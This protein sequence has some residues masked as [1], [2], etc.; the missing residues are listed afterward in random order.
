MLGEKFGRGV[1]PLE[2]GY[3]VEI[4]IVQRRR[5]GLERVMRATDVDDDTI[6]IERLGDE[7]R[8]DDEGCAVQRLR[9]P[10][11]GAAERMGD[12]DVIANFNGEQGTSSGIS[13][14]L[15]KYA[16]PGVKNLG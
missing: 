3:L 11:H 12:H 5:Y 16:I 10:E 13:N 4:A 8:V 9:G 2:F 7:G 14:G 15:A 1:A 6:V